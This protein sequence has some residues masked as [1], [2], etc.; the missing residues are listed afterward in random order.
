MILISKRLGYPPDFTNLSGTIDIARLQDVAA[1]IALSIT[2]RDCSH[3]VAMTVIDYPSSGRI[4]IEGLASLFNAMLQ[5]SEN[6][7]V[8]KLPK[9]SV[10]FWVGDAKRAGEFEWFFTAQDVTMQDKHGNRL[11]TKR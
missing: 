1:A 11:V 10:L 6:R 2:P 3:T 9:K 5:H 7:S 8:A 4:S